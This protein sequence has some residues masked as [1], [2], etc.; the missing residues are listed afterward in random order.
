MTRARGRA[1]ALA[2]FLAV[3]APAAAPAQ[4]R[5]GD[6]DF[7]VLTLSWS[8]SWCEAD[9][10]ADDSAQCTSGRPYAF[11]VHGLWPQRERGWPQY[12]DPVGAE[13]PSGSDV[14]AMLDIMP[15]PG[16][17]R[18]Q[19]RKHGA[20]S[21]LEPDDWLALVREAYETVAIPPALRR[22]ERYT[23]VEPRAVETAFR[24]ANPGLPAD[25]IAVTCDERRLREV[26]I[27]LTRS[28]GFTDCPEVDRRSCRKPTVVM[29]PVR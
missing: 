2:A 18:Y 10:D 22:V 9:P 3:A 7:Y 5:A 27:C 17:V 23:M 19:W 11:V 16:L 4:D 24:T 28:L 8:P 14:D 20:C 13:R 21:G 25:G 29:P 26:R 15:D 1:A 12:C 6:F